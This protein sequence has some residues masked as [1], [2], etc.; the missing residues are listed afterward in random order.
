MTERFDKG[1]DYTAFWD[2]VYGEDNFSEEQIAEL[3]K[4]FP[5]DNP[6][7]NDEINYDLPF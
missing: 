5:L 3:R 6:R 4:H 7:S 2:A 1:E